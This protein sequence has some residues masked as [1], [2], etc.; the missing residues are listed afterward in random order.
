MNT[1]LFA[2][3]ALA[4]VGFAIYVMAKG[5]G[6]DPHRVPFMLEQRPAPEFRLKRLDTGEE[7]T[8]SQLKGKPLVLNFWATWC[9]PC[10]YEHPVLEWAAKKYADRATFV[11]IV[12]EDTEANTKRFLETYGWTLM[13]L[14]DPKSTV[15][16]DYAVAG[17]PE[18]YFIRKDGTIALKK[19]EP[20]SEVTLSAGLSFVLEDSGLDKQIAQIQAQVD[21]LKLTSNDKDETSLRTYVRGLVT[22]GMGAAQVIESVKRASAQLQAQ[23]EKQ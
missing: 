14:F 23:K 22:N 1:R 18:T 5:F 4:L 11:G 12:F 10:K 6:S 13:Q 2:G 19:A 8:L 9:G 16:V 3:A 17:V 21:A 20:L 7:V 15:A